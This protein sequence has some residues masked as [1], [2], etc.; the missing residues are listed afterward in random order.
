MQTIQNYPT[1]DAPADRR[2]A[3]RSMRGVVIGGCAL[4]ALSGAALV[5]VT[6]LRTKPTQRVEIATDDTAMTLSST[7]IGHGFTTFEMTNNSTHEHNFTVA[8]L[9]AGTRLDDVPELLVNPD[10]SAV[11]AAV[12]FYGGVNAVAPGDTFAM[13]VDLPIG[14]YVLVDF[15]EGPDGP[16]FLDEP[17]VQPLE[18]VDRRHAG[19]TPHVDVE[20]V[21]GDHFFDIP[22]TI[23]RDSVWEV[24]NRGEQDHEFDLVQLDPGIT[25]EQALERIL[26]SEGED[27]PGREVNVLAGL[28]PGLTAYVEMSLEPG[29]YLAV[30]FYPDVEHD[31]MPHIMEGMAAGFVVE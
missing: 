22:A 18:V 21:E 27:I 25:P 6:N 8:R 11:V 2:P 5:A 4:I 20:V 15:G 17:F 31:G 12:D 7:K 10:Y 29:Q 23:P 24:T 28:S 1:R 19:K 9:E 16:W 3:R 13:T 14:Q 26:S 30:C